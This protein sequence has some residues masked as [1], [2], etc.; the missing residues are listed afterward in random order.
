MYDLP[1]LKDF[2]LR[3]SYK[4]RYNTQ[5]M[6]GVYCSKSKIG[7]IFEKSYTV[8]YGDDINAKK[9]I[10][11]R[12]GFLPHQQIKDCPRG[13]IEVWICLYP[14]KNFSF[15]IIIHSLWIVSSARKNIYDVLWNI[16]LA[17]CLKNFIRAL[18][19]STMC[20]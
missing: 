9:R 7:K 15:L 6:H 17:W 20:F 4:Y 10:Q 18:S 3:N 8:Q 16:C 5:L 13:I 14:A 11:L 12:N 2:V 1:K 19:H